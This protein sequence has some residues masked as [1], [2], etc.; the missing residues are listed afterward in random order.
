MKERRKTPPSGP[1]PAP[2]RAPRL[3][4]PVVIEVR[5][6][7]TGLY[8]LEAIREFIRYEID[9]GAQTEVNER[10]VTPVCAVAIAVDAL[11]ATPKA[12]R[13]ALMEVTGQAIKQITRRAD[14][15]ARDGDEF[16][17]LLRRTLAKSARTHYAPNVAAAVADATREA[18]TPTT[19]SFGIASL[20]EHL[21]RDPDDMISKA[22][23]ALQ[24]ARKQGAGSVLVFDL[25][26]MAEAI[27]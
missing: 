25:R 22:L 13:D 21:V 19:L 16:V 20:T 26:E 9:G 1:I 24:F 27:R 15:L 18:G 8:S 6:P 2:S 17:A 7:R 3:T 11:A 14:R 12:S 4:V 23:T 10:F 5:D